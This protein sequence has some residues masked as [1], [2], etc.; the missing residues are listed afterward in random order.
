MTAGP[1]QAEEPQIIGRAAGC[2]YEFPFMDYRGGRSQDFDTSLRL[3]V[4]R[5]S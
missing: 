3:F 5:P 2:G 1:G 4:I